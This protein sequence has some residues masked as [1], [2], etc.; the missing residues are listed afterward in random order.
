LAFLDLSLPEIRFSHIR[1][2]EYLEHFPFK[3]IHVLRRISYF[4]ALSNAKPAATF[5]E[6]ALAVLDDAAFGAATE[7]RPKFI[8][9]TD[10][11][12]R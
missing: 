8:S 6:S 10:P 11:A 3:L 5:A 1:I 7:I 9:P 12:A 4:V 2:D